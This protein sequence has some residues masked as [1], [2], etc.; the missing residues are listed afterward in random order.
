MA[1]RIVQL[2]IYG[3]RG[4]KHG[5]ITFDEHTVL[6]GANNCGKS[7]VIDALTLALGSVRAVRPLTDH[8]FYGARP[9]PP[10]RI[11]IIVTLTGFPGNRVSGNE[12]WFREGRAVPKW[13]NS[14]NKK[15]MP[16]QEHESDLLCMQIGFAARFDY[17]ELTVETIRYFHDDDSIEDPFDDDMVVPIPNQLLREIGFT[18]LPG[19]RSYDRSPSFGSDLIRRVISHIGAIPSEQILRERDHLHMSGTK[20]FEN[21]EFRAAILDIKK[22]M[23]SLL[24]GDLEL[25]VK[26]TS[27]DCDAILRSLVPHYRYESDFELPAGRHGSG[28]L[29]MQSFAILMQPGQKR[30]EN[31]G[32]LII[33]VEEPELHIPPSLQL[34]MVQSAIS[35]ASQTIWTTHSPRVASYF[36]PS[37]ILVLHNSKGQL[38]ANTFSENL[39]QTAP[40]AVRK[41]FFDNRLQVVEAVLYPRVLIPEGRID[42]EILRLL[43]ENMY[44]YE[45][46]V[47]DGFDEYERFT[48]GSVIG[49]I[50]THDSS[51]LKTYCE[52]RRIHRSCAVLV[53]GDSDGERYINELTSLECP[54]EIVVQWPQDWTIEHVLDW[55]LKEVTINEIVDSVEGVTATTKEEFLDHMMVKQGK[56]RVGLKGNYLFYESLVSFICGTDSCR[57]RT[58]KLMDS[59]TKLLYKGVS[60]ADFV[61]RSVPNGADCNTKI[62]RWNPDGNL[63]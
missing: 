32:N 36:Q 25:S 9:G 63:F 49:V 43:S 19:H 44:K 18:V 29:S 47:R 38:T 27:T 5:V 2:E 62:Y 28:L 16:E 23:A 52:L 54:P 17:D 31:Y 46:H 61:E 50:P 20:L 8:D 21:E 55:I 3:F 11:Q 1:M 51:V 48:F 15:L 39:D 53:D 13:W 37:S 30:R 33:A 42:Y 26:L 24:P 22:E 60:D 56:G 45:S 7:T 6:I 12:K 35:R 59:L 40:N 58:K 4:V 41:L 34:R 57:R 10:D 14:S